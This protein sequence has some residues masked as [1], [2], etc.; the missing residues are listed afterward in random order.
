VENVQNI[1][2]EFI[3]FLITGMNPKEIPITI[4]TEP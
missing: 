3:I 1:S 2:D 4:G